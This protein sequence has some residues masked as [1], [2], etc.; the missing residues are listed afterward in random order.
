MG[1][2]SKRGR[3]LV[4]FQN[5]GQGRVRIQDYGQGRVRLRDKGR[6]PD[7]GPKSRSGF[8][9]AV[10]IEF[11]DRGRGWDLGRGSLSVPRQGVEVEIRHRHRGRLSGHWVKDG[12][13]RPGIGVGFRDKGRGL[14][15]GSKLRFETSVGVKNL[16][17]GRGHVSRHGTSGDSKGGR[18]RFK[19]GTRVSIGSGYKTMVG[20]KSS[21]ETE[22]EVP[23]L[24]PNPRPES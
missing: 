24:D 16:D 20:V 13:S 2:D 11:W 5:M 15:L 4:K 19:F 6:G 22:V 3:V 23:N 8:R 9:T 17:S 18:V 12:F 10:R 1:G 7:F 14:V 21:Y